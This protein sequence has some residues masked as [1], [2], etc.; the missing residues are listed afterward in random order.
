MKLLDELET[1]RQDVDPNTSFAIAQNPKY[2]KQR[3]PRSI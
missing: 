1:Q 2:V 3:G